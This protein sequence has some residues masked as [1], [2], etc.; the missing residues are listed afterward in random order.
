[1]PVILP[2]E[3]YDRW[4]DPQLVDTL[5]LQPLLDSYPSEEMKTYP[6]STLVNSPRN[7]D[8]NCVVRQS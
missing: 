6:V 2:S 8:P 1:M 5:P 4:L 3:S 7:D